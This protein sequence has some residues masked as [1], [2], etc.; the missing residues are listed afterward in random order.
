VGIKIVTE[1]RKARFDY[2]ILETFEAGM[3]L[4]GSE[5]KSLRNGG[6]QLKDSY[7]VF[8]NTELY[9]QNAHI[10]IYTA[11]AHHNHAPERKRKL[12]MHRKE[13]ER[14]ASRVQE[15]GLSLIPLKVYFKEGK[16]KVEIAL[17]KGKKRF[18]KR[19]SIKSKDVA[20]ELNQQKRK[21]R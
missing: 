13:I 21:I 1:N 4:R 10:S 19:E 5:V 15:K 2:S 18:D 12:L 11:S 6:C 17:A 14:L 7:V 9:L 3:V 8:Q 20:R 16:A